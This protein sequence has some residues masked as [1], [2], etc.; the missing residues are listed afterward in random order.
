MSLYSK[1]AIEQLVDLI[2][3]ANPDLP[4]PINSVDYEFSNPQSVTV[5]EEEPT[6]TR[7]LVIAKPSAPYIGSI[8]L[9][10]NRI[11]LVN[12]FRNIEP[13]FIHW[14]ENRGTSDNGSINLREL[15]PTFGK[16]YGI[17][18]DSGLFSNR[19]LTKSTGVY[20]NRFPIYAD[21]HSLLYIGSVY[22]RW[23]VGEDDVSYRLSTPDLEGRQYPD[24]N[25]FSREDYKPYLTDLTFD[26]DYTTI[27]QSS[28]YYTT[29]LR[30]T[31]IGSNNDGFNT[32]VNDLVDRIAGPFETR[33]GRP[34]D[35][36]DV[37][38]HGDYGN[39]DGVR[40]GLRNLMIR[41]IDLPHPSFPGA[42]SDLYNRCCV[43]EI[44]EDCPWG[45]GYLYFHFN[46]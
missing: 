23:L 13:E 14:V 36:R 33:V 19:V 37:I 9:R 32:L 20:G 41:V 28:T 46:N 24:G 29:E 27:V 21:T 16:K 35:S 1:P 6:N 4:F 31:S 38:Y 2:N 34:I 44:P 30:G 45:T 22:I 3:E 43:M 39:D 18:V 7:I 12:L 40:W 15:L 26:K 10:Y 8:D 5:T 17:A 11:N 42:N 25:D